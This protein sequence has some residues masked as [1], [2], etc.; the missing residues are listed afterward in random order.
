[1]RE[2]I[3]SISLS[4]YEIYKQMEEDLK[5]WVT[6]YIENDFK[7]LV[8]ELEKSISNIKNNKWY[9]EVS[10]GFD[11]RYGYF[12]RVSILI[13]I[14]KLRNNKKLQK[15]LKKIEKEEEKAKLT[16]EEKETLL[17]KEEKIK[18]EPPIVLIFII[19]LVIWIS[20]IYLL[21]K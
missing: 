6:E 12:D 8:K 3:V 14:D 18:H 13:D 4:K 20:L 10:G 5:A 19:S 16:K 15:A 11:S 21:W 9:I 2:D 17:Q 1:M 7:P